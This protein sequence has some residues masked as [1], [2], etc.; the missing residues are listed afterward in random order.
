MSTHPGVYLKQ[1]TLG[2][3]C[4][5][6][7]RD[8]RRS[9]AEVLRSTR[10]AD[11]EIATR[12]AEELSRLI[13]TPEHW[14]DPPEGL[15]PRTLELW[16]VRPVVG[17]VEALVKELDDPTTF[18][19]SSTMPSQYRDWDGKPVKPEDF[20]TKLEALTK[21]VS[22]L[23]SE[24]DGWR[25]RA[26]ISEGQLAKMN[27]RILRTK[28]AQTVSLKEAMEAWLEKLWSQGNDEDY[29]QDQEWN[30][31]RFVEA[32]GEKTKLSDVAGR[33]ADLD[34]W[35]ASLKR[36]GRKRKKKDPIGNPD[37]SEAAPLPE[38]SKNIGAG[39]RAEI[40]RCIL[41]FLSDAGLE[42]DR[43]KIK[44][45]GRKDVRNDR[46]AIRWLDET[47]AQ[48]LIDALEDRWRDYYRVQLGLG[49]RPDELITIH[50]NNFTGDFERITLAKL[51]H[52]TLK[53][54]S[55]TINVPEKIRPILRRLLKDRKIAFTNDD[56]NIWPAAKM[57]NREYLQALRRAACKAGILTKVDCRIARRTCA[58]RLLATGMSVKTVADILGTSSE[59]IVLHYGAV[60]PGALDPS[61]AA[62]HVFTQPLLWTGSAAFWQSWRQSKVY[63][64]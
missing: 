8:P 55:R 48:K 3:M 42:V 22:H 26:Q 45:P 44:R 62:M 29:S 64:N 28:S 56:G 27:V 43:K 17:Q 34:H 1:T 20:R 57:F 47:Q 7:W 2:G 54:G 30:V 40:R 16:G 58:T 51:E 23:K 6:R 35:L 32:F 31:R 59:M 39:R 13:R 36:G 25:D 63:V 61:A 24:R 46:G 4:N 33:E 21:T 60:I 37:G 19:T 14:N 50:R 52:L 15:H 9:N 12:I 18:M 49:L 41:K 5:I 53:E 10:T 38:S 11:F